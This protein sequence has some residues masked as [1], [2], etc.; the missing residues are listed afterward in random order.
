MD[1]PSTESSAINTVEAASLF[2]GIL[3]DD[4]PKRADAQNDPPP[5][6]TADAPAAE[7][8]EPVEVAAED[9]PE[10]I[11]KIDGKE[12]PVK[13]SE[14]KNGYQRQADYTRKT[15]EVAETRKTADAEIAQA[16]QERN[17]RA[18]QLAELA[19][20]TQALLNVQTQG[21]NWQNLLDTDPVEYLKQQRTAQERQAH[22]QAINQERQRLHSQQQAETAEAQ[23]NYLQSQQ[24]E[25][26][27]KLPEWSDETKAK[28]EKAALRD[29]LVNEGFDADSLN[30]ITDARAVVLARKAMLYDQ[31]MSKAQ[32]AAK[33][34]A[35]LPTK[36]E[37]PG[38]P[39]AQGLDRR[40]A[41]FQRLGKTGKIEDAAALF[42]Q[43]L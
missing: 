4:P 15:M 10:V 31:M 11:I 23:A 7:K 35:T 43:I 33:K 5:E 34:V 17:Q 1:N 14:L 30:Q 32:A 39:E 36:V 27:A 26:L 16:R 19:N 38:S 25:L 20:Q 18:A 24:R 6:K 37:R 41:S 3:S 28:A 22:L 12:V 21:V 2:A 29:F 9:D 8:A 40:A 42:A 13:L